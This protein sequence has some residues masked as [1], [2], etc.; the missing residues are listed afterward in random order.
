MTGQEDGRCQVEVMILTIT[1]DSEE[2]SEDEDLIDGDDRQIIDST[3][4]VNL[5]GSI[6]H[7]CAHLFRTFRV[8]SAYMRAFAIY[9]KI[10]IIHAN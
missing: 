3:E 6:A 2:D 5:L 1:P 8:H 10:I 9:S 4:T 7:I